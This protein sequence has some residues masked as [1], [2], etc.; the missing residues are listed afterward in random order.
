MVG[1]MLKA[2]GSLISGRMW[3]GIISME[4]PEQQEIHAASMLCSVLVPVMGVAAIKNMQSTKDIRSTMELS[5]PA[6]SMGSL[7][8][9]LLC[10]V[11]TMTSNREDDCITAYLWEIASRETR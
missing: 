8:C 1:M 3:E 5:V 6:C 7:V 11:L 10:I 9:L 2:M 4:G